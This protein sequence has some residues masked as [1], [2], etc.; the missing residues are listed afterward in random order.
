[1]QITEG[2][3]SQYMDLY[4]EEYGKPINRVQARN[5]LTALVCLMESVYKYCNKTKN[6]ET[7]CPNCREVIDPDSFR[8]EVSIEEFNI[9]GFC[10]NCQDLTFRN[11]RQQAN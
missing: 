8:D 7:L 10:Q 1:M 6:M 11:G 3:V 9:S 2:R 5:E 4:L